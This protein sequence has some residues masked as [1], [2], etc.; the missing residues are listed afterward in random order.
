MPFAKCTPLGDWSCVQHSNRVG[1]GDWSCMLLR[2]SRQCPEI[3]AG[4]SCS[5]RVDGVAPARRLQQNVRSPLETKKRRFF[6]PLKLL[7]SVQCCQGSTLHCSRLMMSM[8][9]VR[10][11]EDGKQAEPTPAA[12]GN[13]G[14]RLRR[15]RLVAFLQQQA[16]R[17][18]R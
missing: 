18:L 17:W 16:R 7:P 12:Q 14:S 10:F 8:R 4:S 1:F 9:V 11:D 2:Q 13:L 15:L 5:S 3:E 6:R